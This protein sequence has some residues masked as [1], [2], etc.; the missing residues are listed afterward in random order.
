MRNVLFH[1]P[2]Y[3][4]LLMVVCACQ[5]ENSPAN[6]PAGFELDER[7]QMELIAAEPLVADPVDMCID[8]KG[9]M[10][11]V[12]MHGYPLDVSGSG[13]VK[14]LV[15]TDGDGV[16]DQH[17]VFADSLILPTGIM[18]W[19]KGVLVTD[20][21]HV[22]YLEDTNED[23]IADKREVILTGFARSNPQHNVN[24]PRYGL[25]NWIYLGHEPAVTTVMFTEKLGDK[26]SEIHFPFLPEGPQLPVNAGGRGIRFKP[27]GSGLERLASRTQFGHATDKWGERFL[28][29]NNNHLIHEVLPARYL[30]KNPFFPISNVTQSVSDHGNAAEVYPITDNPEHQLLTDIGVM[31]SACGVTPY[32]GGAFPEPFDQVIF[33]AEPVSN[34]VHA[35]ILQGKGATFTG[36]KLYQRSEF[37]RSRDAWFR[38]VNMY[39]GPDGALYLLDYHRKI[40]EHP[41]WMA[42]EVTQSG[43]LYEGTDKGRIYRISPKGSEKAAWSQSID[44]EQLTDQALIEKLSHPN[45]WWRTNAQRILVE[46]NPNPLPVELVELA[47]NASQPLGRLH[48][49]WTLHGVGNLQ[50]ELVK[51]ALQDPEAGVRKNALKLAEFFPEKLVAWD[52]ELRA[53]VDDPD[54]KVRFQ[55]VN[56]L[57][58]ISEEWAFATRM[59][60]L[61]KDMDDEWVQLAVLAAPLGNQEDILEELISGYRADQSGYNEMIEK[62]A[63]MQAARDGFEEVL[64]VISP[65]VQ[66]T[67]SIMGWEPF[68]IKGMASGLQNSLPSGSRW[69]NLQKEIILNLP[70]ISSIPLKNAFIDL[71]TLGPIPEISAQKGIVNQAFEITLN[72]S[73]KE[74]ERLV[75]LRIM[76]LFQPEKASE[77]LKKLIQPQEPVRLQQEV[78]SYLSKA[79][80][81]GYADFLME[82]WKGLS[83]EVRNAAVGSLLNS[84]PRIHALLDGLEHGTVLPSHIPWGN[85]VF[86]MNQKD[87]AIRDKARAL[88]VPSDSEREDVI[89]SFQAALELEGIPEKGL[90]VY[91]ENCSICHQMTEE[92]GELYGPDL[93][94]LRNRRYESILKDILDPNLSIAD[95]YDLWQIELSDSE[96]VQGI[97]SHE[98]TTAIELVQAGGLTR[99]IS[100]SE[101]SSMQA[102]PVSGMAQ[103]LENQISV[104]EMA[105]LLAFIKR[106]L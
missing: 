104:E 102:L 42:D 73:A 97:I 70:L 75:W 84:H 34:L 16:M 7:F 29:N 101:I 40:I 105:D 64:K 60:V 39:L 5:N 27:D 79:A 88:L 20:P 93:A 49:L 82:R 6:L 83:P 72:T 99:T 56:T 47:R 38:P 15:D 103:G 91:E 54:P 19:K 94:S 68:A 106:G 53:M 4:Y 66:P 31:T 59:A 98:T 43:A 25:D 12:E 28:I 1:I 52:L 90:Q 62:A 65:V 89:R 13:K 100:R 46:R 26:G 63:R 21:P 95:G 44:L 50:A 3:L 41:E 57:S 86:L 18:A 8:G 92:R 2:A 85:T 51:E 33:T 96:A 74:E 87:P 81:G 22:L 71:V 30:G 80:E 24:S 61:K 23:G 32:L 9:R 67:N 36:S 45:H 11:V 58:T 10:F 55:L 78:L 35:D 48:A 76:G 77:E 14:L 69:E 17:T 37:L